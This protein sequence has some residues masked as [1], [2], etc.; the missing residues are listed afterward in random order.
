MKNAI[1]LVI[2]LCGYAFI[3]VSF[4]SFLN[5]MF[6]WSIGYKGEQIPG[7]PEFAILFVVLGVVTSAIGWFLNKKFST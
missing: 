5:Y 2:Q 6:D 1:I 4:V 7:E 3:L